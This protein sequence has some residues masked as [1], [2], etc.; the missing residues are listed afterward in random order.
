MAMESCCHVKRLPGASSAGL[1]GGHQPLMPAYHQLHAAAT[2]LEARQAAAACAWGLRR[3]L[4]VAVRRQPPC[5]SCA[6]MLLLGLWVWVMQ[7]VL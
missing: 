2:S 7:V 5:A 6:V 1:R 3:Q 4:R